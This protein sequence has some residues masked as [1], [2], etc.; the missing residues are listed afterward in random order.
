MKL[1]YQTTLSLCFKQMCTNKKLSD[2]TLYPT[3][4]RTVPPISRLS[5]PVHAL[6]KYF[7]WNRVGIITQNS[8]QWSQWNAL[9]SSLKQEGVSVSTPQIMA[10]GVHYNESGLSRDFQNLLHG[11]AQESRGKKNHTSFVARSF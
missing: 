10:F 11:A 3:F 5:P 9:V 4:A 6:M 2:K 7:N 1:L 8:Q